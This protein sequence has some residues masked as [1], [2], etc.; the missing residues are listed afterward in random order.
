MSDS[1]SGCALAGLSYIAT[2]AVVIGSGFLIW[3]WFEPDGFWDIIG[4]LILWAILS[5]IGHFIVSAIF[6]GIASMFDN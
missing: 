6:V 4:F 5:G 2:A 3:N 1:N